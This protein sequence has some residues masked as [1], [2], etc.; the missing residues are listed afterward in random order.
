MSTNNRVFWGD[1]RTMDNFA[2]ASMSN[3]FDDYFFF[4]LL[5]R[6]AAWPWKVRVGANSPSLCPTMFS[7][8]KIGMN[9]F[10]LCTASDRPTNSGEMVERR[11]Q[12]LMIFLEPTPSVCTFLIRCSSM[13]GPFFIERAILGSPASR[14]GGY[15]VRGLTMKRD[16]VLFLRVL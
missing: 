12:V 15:F 16:V 9:F 11:D 13:N 8:T 4:S 5:F 7:E 14:N 3:S 1:R 10:P 6:S 2:L